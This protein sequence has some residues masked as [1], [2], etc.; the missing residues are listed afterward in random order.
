MQFLIFF[1]DE[2]I[3][4]PLIFKSNKVYFASSLIAKPTVEVIEA[5]D[6]IM[7]VEVIEATEVFKTTQILKM[8]NLIARI[9]LF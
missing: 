7:S 4:C 9:T 3:V 2:L 5:S 6:V 8:I 1:C